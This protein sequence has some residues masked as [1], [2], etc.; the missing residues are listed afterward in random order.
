MVWWSTTGLLQ[1][2]KALANGVEPE[3]PFHPE[4]YRYHAARL[5][6]EGVTEEEAIERAKAQSR[7]SLVTP[8]LAVAPKL[9]V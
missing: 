5:V 7:A 2:A 4:E 8:E 6:L 3:A 9:A 1:A